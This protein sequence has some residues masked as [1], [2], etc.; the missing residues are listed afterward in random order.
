MRVDIFGQ[1]K[2]QR[3]IFPDWMK[4]EIMNTSFVIKQFVIKQ[5][6]TKFCGT[7]SSSYRAADQGQLIKLQPHLD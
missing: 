5:F 7:I 3:L 1:S 4:S 6:S 2:L